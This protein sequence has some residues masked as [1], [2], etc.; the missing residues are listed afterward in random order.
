MH[1]HVTAGTPVARRGGA[2]EVAVRAL[3]LVARAAVTVGV[4]AAG[5]LLMLTISATASAAEQPS[6]PQGTQ[7]AEA[8]ST[9]T[10]TEATTESAQDQQKAGEGKRSGLLGGVVG[11][12][13]DTTSNLTKAAVDT[14]KTTTE[15]VTK[16]VRHTVKTVSDTVK[17]VTG[18]L[19]DT[20][21]N[22]T[23][24]ADGI[25]GID[26]VVSTKPTVQPVATV[27]QQTTAEQAKPSATRTAVKVKAK[28]ETKPA[29]PT[30]RAPQRHEPT[31][32]DKSVTRTAELPESKAA[33]KHSATSNDGTTSPVDQQLP[34]TPC[35]ASSPSAAHADAPSKK[36]VAVTAGVAGGSPLQRT[37]VATA[38][39]VAHAITAA[40]LPC[41]SPD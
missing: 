18:G 31:S 26:D 41:T 17:T 21:G 7:T 38:A 11:G 24:P 34:S 40:A 39:P 29:Q 27:P 14:V 25:D 8:E 30:K 10:S 23:K 2:R 5:W 9:D 6:S 1:V 15:T 36:L 4:A 32:T 22:V 33:A 3:R 16:T 12:L 37:G 20:V 35:G 19:R 28:T 13:A